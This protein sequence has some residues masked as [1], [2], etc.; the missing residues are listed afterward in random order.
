ME[1]NSDLNGRIHCP[2]ARVKTSIIG[3]TVH[4]FVRVSLPTHVNFANFIA[5]QTATSVK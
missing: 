4:M 1:H 3:A 5:L 2:V